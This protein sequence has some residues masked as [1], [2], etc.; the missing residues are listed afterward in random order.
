[1]P[2]MPTNCKSQFASALAGVLMFT[3]EW[4]NEHLSGFSGFALNGSTEPSKTR[5]GCLA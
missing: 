5:K 3:L 4:S 2:D 1:L